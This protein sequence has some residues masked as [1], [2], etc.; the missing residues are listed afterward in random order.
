VN[1]AGLVLRPHHTQ[2]ARLQHFVTLPFDQLRPHDD[3]G[4]PSLAIEG[5]EHHAE[6][7][8]GCWRQTTSPA[9]LTRAVVASSHTVPAC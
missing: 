3:V 2:Q 6:A 1:D 5:D 4:L 8:L 9:G 7:E